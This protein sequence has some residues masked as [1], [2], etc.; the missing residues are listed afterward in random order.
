MAA[1]SRPSAVASSSEIRAQSVTWAKGLRVLHV[2]CL[3][4]SLPLLY[5]T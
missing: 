4:S 1:R 5:S 2:Q 3:V